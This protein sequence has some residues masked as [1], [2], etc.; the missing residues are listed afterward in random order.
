MRRQIRPL[1]KKNDV[2]WAV[3]L[4]VNY[5]LTLFLKFGG[6]FYVPFSDSNLY[7]RATQ[8]LFIHSILGNGRNPVK[9]WLIQTAAFGL[10]EAVPQG[11]I[12]QSSHKRQTQCLPCRHRQTGTGTL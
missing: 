2:R 6:I 5:P 12:Y 8:S 3:L 10:S 7:A 1:N 11:Y 9:N 4:Y